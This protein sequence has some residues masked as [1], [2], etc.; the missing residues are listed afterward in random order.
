M[1]SK[2]GFLE[3]VIT[4]NYLFNKE[5]QLKQAKF[6]FRLYKVLYYPEFYFLCFTRSTYKLILF[7]P[8]DK[9]THLST[10]YL[11]IF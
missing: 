2:N 7:W 6:S 9:I 3:K 10:N 8:Q 1:P 11:K 4:S 5:L